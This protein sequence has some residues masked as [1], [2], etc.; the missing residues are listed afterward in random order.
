MS[1][2]HGDTAHRE[3]ASPARDVA[4]GQVAF[5]VFIA[6]CVALHPG[7][8]LK[9][10]EGGISNYGVHA[11]TVVPYTLALGLA[12][13]T[14]LRAS[15]SV[16]VRDGR[17]RRLRLILRAYAALVALTLVS[18]YPY[19]LDVALKDVHDGVGVCVFVFELVTAAVMVRALGRRRGW[20]LV[21]V[22]GF[23]VGAVT[24]VGAAHLLFVAQV[25]TSVA[26]AVILV[27]A[28]AAWA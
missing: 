7:F 8:V 23:V 28:T 21:L 26:Y 15:R 5:A 2:A 13:A 20:L 19:A 17:S 27:S 12:S 3:R 6:V 10:N 14:S 22:A 16:R 24:F 18:T 25:V 4:A 11:R 9:S 1:D